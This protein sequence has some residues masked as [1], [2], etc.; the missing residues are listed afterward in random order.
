MDV[1]KLILALLKHPFVTSATKNKLMCWKL[2]DITT[3]CLRKIEHSQQKWRIW[4]LCEKWEG[5]T[6]PMPWDHNSKAKRHCGENR[7]AKW[8]ETKFWCLLSG[9][10]SAISLSKSQHSSFIVFFWKSSDSG[11]DVFQT[12]MVAWWQLSHSYQV[13]YLWVT[14]AIAPICPP[15]GWETPELGEHCVTSQNRSSWPVIEASS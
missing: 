2:K 6:P 8:L 3:D 7:P 1:Q 13:V 4:G 11:F 5:K 15:C 12:Y 14:A 10:I 9:Q